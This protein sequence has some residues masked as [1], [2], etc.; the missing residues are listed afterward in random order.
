L[1]SF[2]ISEIAKSKK[3]KATFKDSQELISSNE[4]YKNAQIDLLIDRADNV[5][6]V[7]EMKFYNKPYTVT[8][9]YADELKLKLAE[10][11]QNMLGVR[12]SLFLCLVTANGL[13]QNQHSLS[14]VNNEIGASELFKF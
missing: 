3:L 1:S 12:K 8:K 14:L 5:V 11:E 7:C 6:T 13:V 10:F 2:I 4:N 9:K